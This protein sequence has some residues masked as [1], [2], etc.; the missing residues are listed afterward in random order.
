MTSEELARPSDVADVIPGLEDF[1]SSDMTMPVLQILPKEGLFQ[2][3]LSGV[4]Y[5]TLEN[6]ILLGL[7]KQRILWPA[8]MGE[9]KEP[10][11]CRSFDAVTGHTAEGFPWEAS[12]FSTDDVDKADPD[13]PHHYLA[14]CKSCNLAEW[15]T[16]PSRETPWCALQHTYAILVNDNGAYVPSLLTLARS[17]IKP[18]NSYLTAFARTKKPLYTQYTNLSLEIRSRG[19]NPFSVPKFMRA[20]TTPQDDYP[21]YAETYYSIRDYVQSPRGFSTATESDVAGPG[22]AP[23]PAAPPASAPPASPA[24]APVAEPAAA[25]AAPAATGDLPF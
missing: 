3:R 1:E 21:Y 4:T 20:G 2:D 22:P 7:I 6:C 9:N 17:G 16:H 15:D 18:S 19:G 13:D 12:G 8:K 5:E 14:P 25:D 11:L 23:A 10:P 24:P